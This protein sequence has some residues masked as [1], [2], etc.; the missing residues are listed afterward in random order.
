MSSFILVVRTHYVTS[1]GLAV[2]GCEGRCPRALVALWLLS[3][4]LLES[5]KS[6]TSFLCHLVRRKLFCCLQ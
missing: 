4:L 2:S 3:A 5:R 1:Q 6:C